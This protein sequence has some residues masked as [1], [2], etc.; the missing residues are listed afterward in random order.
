MYRKQNL[1]VTRADRSYTRAY[2][3]AKLERGECL[4]CTNQAAPDRSRCL[5]CLRVEAAK[6]V[7]ERNRDKVV[8]FD[9]YGRKCVCCELTYDV[10]FLTLD[11]VNNDGAAHRRSMSGY[12]GGGWGAMYRWA[13][14]NN[15]PDSVQ[16]M[17]WNCNEARRINGVCPHQLK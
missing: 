13:I 11:H 14:K 12:N 3:N 9:R 17:C 4:S 15:F 1:D 6:R 2:R 5:E 10:V 16:S 7:V 8:C